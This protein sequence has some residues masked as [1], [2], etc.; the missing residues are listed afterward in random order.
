MDPDE[1]NDF[2]EAPPAQDG[3]HLPPQEEASE[4]SLDPVPAQQT[5]ESSMPDTSIQASY[6]MMN[7]FPS[8]QSEGKE[9][10]GWQESVWPSMGKMESDHL[11]EVEPME[12]DFSKRKSEGEIQPHPTDYPNAPEL[13]EVSNEMESNISNAGTLSSQ[14]NDDFDWAISA[15]KEP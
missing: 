13:T 4:P 9:S 8:E 6:S 3:T 11:A 5:V 12:V 10:Q 7:N 1:F 15:T 2:E 14:V